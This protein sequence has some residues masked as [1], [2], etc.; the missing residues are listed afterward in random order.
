[1]CPKFSSVSGE[2]GGTDECERMCLILLSSGRHV[3]TV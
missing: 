2:G 3:D 1:M